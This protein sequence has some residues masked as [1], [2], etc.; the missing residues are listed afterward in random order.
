MFAVPATG[1]VVCAH[2]GLAAGRGA[3]GSIYAAETTHSNREGKLV[4]PLE[5]R[6]ERF[7]PHRSGA[8]DLDALVEDD[9]EACGGTERP[10]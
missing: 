2:F 5:G 3:G 7:T 6:P 10:L 4:Q 9:P 1:G 8:V